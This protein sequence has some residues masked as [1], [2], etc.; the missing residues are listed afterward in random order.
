MT[1]TDT[2]VCTLGVGCYE[3]GICYAAANGRPEQCPAIL[4]GAGSRSPAATDAEA[5]ERLGEALFALSD[6]LRQ[7]SGFFEDEGNHAAYERVVAAFQSLTPQAPSAPDGLRELANELRPYAKKPVGSI[8]IDVREVAKI[9]E[10]LDCLAALTPQAPSA[11]DGLREVLQRI[12]DRGYISKHIEEERDDHLALKAALA[13][14]TEPPSEVV[15]LL[16]PFAQAAEG[17][18]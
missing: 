12:L 5:V 17:E 15:R 1:P 16:K 2:P 6:K 4:N 13:T 9:V 18:G 10:G 14:L 8:R 3:T 11:P 7:Q